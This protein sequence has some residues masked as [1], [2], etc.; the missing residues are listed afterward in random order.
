MLIHNGF[1]TIL[2]VAANENIS[3]KFKH[4]AQLQLQRMG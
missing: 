2:I 4:V 3:M 1:K